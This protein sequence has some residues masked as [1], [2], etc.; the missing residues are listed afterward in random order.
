MVALYCECDIRRRHHEKKDGRWYWT[1]SGCG[2]QTA[3]PLGAIVTDKAKF[4]AALA[5][6]EDAHRRIHGDPL[7]VL[8][9]IGSVVSGL[10][11]FG[12]S[13][14]VGYHFYLLV[15]RGMP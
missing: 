10:A 5:E 7:G 9:A 12:L 2:T 15:T 6:R 11:I 8:M 3:M 13:A 1:C 4:R 14:W